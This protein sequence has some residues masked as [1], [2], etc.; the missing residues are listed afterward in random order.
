MSILQG[1]F[2]GVRMTAAALSQLILTMYEPTQLQVTNFTNFSRV[3]LSI[4][5]PQTTSDQVDLLNVSLVLL[6]SNG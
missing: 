5:Y 3:M 6:P 4:E 2:E 1:S